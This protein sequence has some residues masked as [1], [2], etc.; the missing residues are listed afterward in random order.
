V[1]LVIGAIVG[2]IPVAIV[3][4]RDPANG[5]RDRAAGS[6]PATAG[7]VRRL[8]AAAQVALAVLLLHNAGLLIASARAVQGVSLGFRP[9]STVSLRINIPAPTFNDRASRELLLRRLVDEVSHVPGVIA[10]GLANALPLTPGRQDIAM[11]V[12][13]RPFKADGTDPL[14]DY[15]VVS[16]GYFAAMRI[17]LVG[18]RLFTDDDASATYTPLV[19]SRSLARRLFPD[20]AD[21]VGQRL[22]FGPGAPWMP[23]VGVVGDARNRSL[24][25]DPR[26]ELYTPGLGTWSP[27]AFRS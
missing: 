23:I 15:R 7:R 1:L 13:G 4:H 3:A 21:P 8:L 27:F 26:P 5:L 19:I 12:E 25:E 24:T 10:A 18:G 22:R 6:S 9:D 16:A 2:A 11:A 20:G 14:A 17:P